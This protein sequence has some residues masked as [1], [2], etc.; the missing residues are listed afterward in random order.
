MPSRPD[1]YVDIEHSDANCKAAY[2]ELDD[3]DVR[4]FLRA[5]TATLDSQDG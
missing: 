1:S 4:V 3:K 5:L 2:N